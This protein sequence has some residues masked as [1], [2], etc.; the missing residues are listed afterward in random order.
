MGNWKLENGRKMK[1]GQGK[2]TFASSSATDFNNEEYEGDWE[3][4]LMHGFGTYKY[5]S[6]NI[7]EGSWEKGKM[8]GKGV[9]QFADGSKYDG[10]WADNLMHGVGEY[11]DPDGVHWEGIF[12][13]GTFQS[14]I[15]KK[16]HAEKELKD[17][18]AMYEEGVK[19]LFTK[20]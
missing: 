5:L 20:F 6:G 9:M 17:K 3:D 18:M 12:I 15:Q 7:Y 8:S 16:L 13:N 1:H 14:K 10:E 19:E 2:L 4:D 11:D